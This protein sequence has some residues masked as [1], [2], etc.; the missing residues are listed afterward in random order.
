MA[1]INTMAK[2]SLL[3]FPLSFPPSLFCARESDT[4]WKN[5]NNNNNLEGKRLS[6]LAGLEGEAGA[7]KGIKTWSGQASAIKHLRAADCSHLE[8]ARPAALCFPCSMSS[9]GDPG[10]KSIGWVSASLTGSRPWQGNCGHHLWF[11]GR[12]HGERRQ[13]RTFVVILFV[14]IVDVLG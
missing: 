8:S 13:I 2:Q 7:G 9:R 1:W 5:N 11:R 6:C 12:F 14:L 3:F 10:Q 4:I